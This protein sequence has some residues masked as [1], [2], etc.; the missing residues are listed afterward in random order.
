MNARTIL[1]NVG[2]NSI[3]YVVNVAVGLFLSPFINESLGYAVV[4]VWSLVVC[5][6]GYY[7]L[8]DI[9][10]RSAVGHY[11]ATYHARRDVAQVNRTLSTAMAMMCVVGAIAALVTIAAAFWLPDWYAAIR[12]ARHSTEANPLE[13]FRDPATLRVVILLMGF[14]FAVNFPMVIYS[15][16]IYSVQRIVLQNVIAIGQLLLRAALTWYALRAGYGIVGLAIVVVGTNAAG[17]IA[18]IV[19]ARRVLPEL[20]IARRHVQRESA[21]EL[22][23]YGGY[24]V[25]VNVGDT[26]LLYTSGF[27]IGFALRDETAITY[28]AVP[29]SQ[30]IPYFMSI[31]QAVTWSLTP[32]F[33]SHWATGRI[34]DV[35][36]L[37]DVGSRSV[38][39][40]AS[41]VAGGLWLLGADFLRVWQGP[42][43]YGGENASY[44]AAS[45][46]SLAI[47]TGATLLRATQNCG[48][49]ALFAM[50]EVRYL[51]LLTLAEAAA[52]VVLSVVL[53]WRWGL[54]GV[55]LATLLPV[56]VTQGFV[57]PRHLLRELDANAPRF[58]WS[59]L[60][61][62][63]PVIATM[64]LVD[65]GIRRFGGAT[66][67]VTSWPTFLARGAA[68]AVPALLVGLL[69]GTSTVE[70]RAI[71]A[72]LRA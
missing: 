11:V 26:V 64:A 59:L 33:T 20:E 44:F 45:V 43:F 2:S 54:P 67:V 49:Q 19:G 35:R 29:A 10:I 25:L 3:G 4:G 23:A 65:W 52:N 58:A 63:V 66:L 7:G 22:L 24:N 40:L 70:R 68:L 12:A 56:L 71:V 31:V 61:A 27:I 57:L 13:V 48:R 53:V 37:L 46:T 17:W 72:R 62:S 8:L 60:R 36:G 15:T 41:L 18:T 47:L 42:K 69:L 28:Y 38:V 39:L 6:V 5:F 30:L 14:G 9:G 51:G 16:V 34:D 21:R 55:A 50:R 1:R 32:V